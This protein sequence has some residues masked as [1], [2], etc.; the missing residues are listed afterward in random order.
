MLV[1]S[2]AGTS[3]NS[4]CQKAI[5]GVWKNTPNLPINE[6]DKIASEGISSN[7]CEVS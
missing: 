1:Y 7:Y 4:G 3:Y 5:D 6:A 2:K